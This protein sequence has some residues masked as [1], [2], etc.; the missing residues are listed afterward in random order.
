MILSV[1]SKTA[2]ADIVENPG[3][4][5]WQDIGFR[6][7]MPVPAGWLASTIL[8]DDPQTLCGSL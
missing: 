7:A 1:P 8:F 5:A 2:C 6:E 3:E 4:A